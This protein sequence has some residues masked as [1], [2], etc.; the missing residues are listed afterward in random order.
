[1]TRR[2]LPLLAILLTTAC[3][4]PRP[5]PIVTPPAIVRDAVLTVHLFLG[6][7]A[8]DHKLADFRVEPQGGPQHGQWV[9]TDSAGNYTWPALS[10]ETTGIC[11]YAAGF[12]RECL[13]LD[14]HV[15]HELSISRAWSSLPPLSTSGRL[16]IRNGQPFRW[17][18]VSAFRL[19]DRFARGEDIGPFLRAYDGFTVLRVWV[20]VNWDA[21]FGWEAPPVETIKAFLRRVAADGFYVELTLLTDDAPVRGPPARALVEALAQAPRP[22]NLVLEAGNE[23]Q[24]HKAIDTAALRGTL[25]RSGFLHASGDSSDRFYGSYLTAHTGRDRGDWPRRAHDLL[26]Y[27]NG[28]GPDAPT[29]PAH[30]VPG[31]CDEPGKRE[32]VGDIATE[33][34]AYFAACALMGAGATFHSETGKQA[35]LPTPDEARLAAIALEA[36]NAFPADAPNG[37][38]RRIDEHGAS[39]RTYVIGE[40]YMVRIGP[41]T[42]AAPEPGWRALDADGVLW[43]R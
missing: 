34:R 15:T 4:P 41:T 25:E 10:L 11:T 21:P 19:L 40:R 31:V 3:T 32:D 9:V 2:L 24:V 43:S 42:P 18:G 30:K 27:Y 22:T 39:L 35:D 7:Q 16:F 29:D 23:P 6:D 37:S 38:Y 20:S 1:M 5:P 26:E 28:G 17:K 12:E 8:L 14:L 36:L 33:W 13:P